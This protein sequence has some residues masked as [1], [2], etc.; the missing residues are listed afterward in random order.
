MTL[1]QIVLDYWNA[2]WF[3]LPMYVAN[4]IPVFIKNLN[5]LNIPVDFRRKFMNRRIFGDHKTWRGLVIGTLS[6]GIVSLLQRRGFLIGIILGFGA[7]FGDLIG[8]FI[9]KIRYKPR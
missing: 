2:I 3:I 5:V 8:S 6:G 9:K 4:M 1:S 7:L